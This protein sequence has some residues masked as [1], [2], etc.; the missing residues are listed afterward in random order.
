LEAVSREVYSFLYL[1]FMLWFIV[2][3]PPVKEPFEKVSSKA[4]PG[5]VGDV[6]APLVA[7]CG[8]GHSTRK[9]RQGRSMR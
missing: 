8:G 4:Q 6:R 5:W 9:R 1:G 2:P 3:V 7:K